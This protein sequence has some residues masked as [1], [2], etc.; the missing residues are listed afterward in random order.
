MM[1]FRIDD[2]NFR[3]EMDRFRRKSESGFKDAI[4]KATLELVRFAKLKVR[5]YTRNSKVKS[6]FLVNNIRKV[7]TN[8]GLTGEVISAAGYS[9]AFEEGTRPHPITIKN[10]RVLAGPYRGR[11]AGWVVSEKSKS[12]GYATYGKQVNHPGTKPYPFLYPAWKSACGLFEKLM[13]EALK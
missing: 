10:K 1:T 4:L 5:D 12:M 6:S 8:N 3:Q 13:R 11:P 2:S 9:Q 7:I